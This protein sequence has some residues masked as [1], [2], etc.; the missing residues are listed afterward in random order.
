MTTT[1]NIIQMVISIL[2][3]LVILFQAKGGGL[4]AMFGQDSA[5][6]RTK[7]GL[8]KLLFQ[9]TVALGILFV[10]VSIISVRVATS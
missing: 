3:V 1:L 10:V 2:L 6:F 8:E 5:V 9:A 7:R 4:G